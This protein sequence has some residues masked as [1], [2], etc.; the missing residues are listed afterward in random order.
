LVLVH[1]AACDGRVWRHELE[2]LSDDFIVIAWDAPGCG[3]SADPPGSFDLGDFAACLAGLLD[4]LA[5]ERAHVLGH[6]WGSSV[7]L[8]LW[9]DRPELVASMV[10][11][12]GYAGWAG[13]LPPDEVAR[14]L[15]FAL[16]AAERAGGDW[17]PRSMPGLY[18]PM[19][20]P[21]RAAEL[22]EVMADIRPVGTRV[23]AQ[24]LAAADLRDML[25]TVTV[26]T[27]L[28]NGD[29]DERAPL[30]VA[31]ALEAAIPTAQLV[32]LPGLGHECAL[33]DP[34]RFVAEVRRFVLSVGAGG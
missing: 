16:D 10:L 4:A 22:A 9:R 29:A 26:P 3:A 27:L 28:L 23:M 2:V 25:G 6:S 32:V 11:V 31:R 8:E 17:D 24:A 33:E 14:R 1:G 15:A 12:G 34:E 19:L 21:A 5:V 7:V 30:A 20:A 13:S 18:S